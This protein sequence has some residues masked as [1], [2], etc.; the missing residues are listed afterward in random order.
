MGSRYKIMSGTVFDIKVPDLAVER[1]T[2]SQSIYVA[3]SGWPPIS[4]LQL[5]FVKSGRH[6]KTAPRA[7]TGTVKTVPILS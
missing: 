7:T 2:A 5:F 6:G 4:D 3:K 1:H